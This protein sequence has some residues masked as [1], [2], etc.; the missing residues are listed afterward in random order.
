VVTTDSAD[1]AR[2]CEAEKV[3]DVVAGE[4]L[5]D[6]RVAR[7]LLVAQGLPRILSEGGPRVLAELYAL[8]LIDE[9]CLALSPM[10]TC[11]AEP[12]M[13]DGAALPVPRQLALA[14]ACERDEF[15]FL[16]YVRAG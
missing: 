9:L 3:A 6:L 16:R 4:R 11:G 8:D 1:P 5:V 12:R 14:G 2:V 7:E 13:T 15:L 10:V